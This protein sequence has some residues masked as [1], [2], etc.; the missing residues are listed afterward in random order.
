MVVFVMQYIE[1]SCLALR[2]LY[3]MYVKN[4]RKCYLS[5]QNVRTLNDTSDCK[6][7]LEHFQY[8]IVVIEI[9]LVLTRIIKKRIVMMQYLSIINAK[10]A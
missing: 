2:H 9:Y 10:L 8:S 1:L 6:T 4:H 3:K 7:T 5:W